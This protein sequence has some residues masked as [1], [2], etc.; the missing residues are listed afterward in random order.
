MPLNDRI[1]FEL[2]RL[3]QAQKDLELLIF[4]KGLPFTCKTTL[5]NLT[6]EQA[7]IKVS[8]PGSVCLEWEPYAWILSGE[9]LEAIKAHIDS[10]DITTGLAEISDFSY[11][12]SKF[13]RRMTVRVVP[14]EPLEVRIIHGQHKMQ[15]TLV[16]ISM[17]G[18]GLVIP[19]QETASELKI[20]D[21]VELEIMLPEGKAAIDGKVHTC[22][23]SEDGTVRLSVAYT[24]NTRDK[25]L[26]LKY[27]ANRR[28]E[29]VRDL[30]EMYEKTYQAKMAGAVP[31]NLASS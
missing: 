26:I 11:V 3:L 2:N 10:F 29:I 24:E 18:A 31:T 30:R 4:Y 15:G 12:G 28:V 13:G 1:I 19:G 7:M 20:G 16:D 25:G 9:P 27:I 22:S 8:P 23:K 5:L 6:G 17:G 21:L 14:K